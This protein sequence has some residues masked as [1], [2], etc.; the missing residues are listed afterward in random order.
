MYKRKKQ[1]FSMSRRCLNNEERRRI[2]NLYLN[3]QDAPQIAQI[4]RLKRTIVISIIKVFNSE[5]ADNGQS[6][7]WAKGP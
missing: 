6:T 3:G 2:I 4:M 1:F 7:R 5:G